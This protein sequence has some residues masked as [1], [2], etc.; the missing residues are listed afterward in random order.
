MEVR[1][2]AI[3]PAYN[4][5]DVIADTIRAVQSI[6]EVSQIVVADDGSTDGTAEV[7][8]A[9]DAR[10][11]LML[12]RNLGKGGALNK[13]LPY[14]KG[15]VLLLLDADLGT[16]AREAEKLLERILSDEADMTIALPKDNPPETAQP[17][18]AS[19]K[20]LAARSG[21]FGLVVR[22]A[23]VGIR[24]LTGRW[25]NAPLAGPRAL[26]REIVEK[27]GGF[28]PR[29]GVEVGLTIDALRM[30]YRVV[31]V[32]VHMA[33]RPS[34]RDLRGFIHRGRQMVDVLLTLARKALRL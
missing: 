23:R 14:A 3:I 30:G 32:P 11:V 33:H 6:P 28:A 10:P 5:A 4:E 9:A 24:V 13:A 7:A 17:D 27:A 2:S 15:D 22:T 8:H 16:S 1:V 31:E 25:V 29:F 18:G 34:G 20:K 19:S 26:K 21:G 12:E